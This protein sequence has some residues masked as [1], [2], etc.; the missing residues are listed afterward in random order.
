MIFG[1]QL[2]QDSPNVAVSPESD[3]GTE[4]VGNFFFFLG[5]NKIRVSPYFDGSVRKPESQHF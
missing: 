5:S 1:H 3:H 2:D 4:S